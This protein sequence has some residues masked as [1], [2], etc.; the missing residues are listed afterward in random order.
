MRDGLGGDEVEEEAAHA[1][2]SS[3]GSEGL[4]LSV[5]PPTQ[6]PTDA[7]VTALRR[8]LDSM[9]QH[10]SPRKEVASGVVWRCVRGEVIATFLMTIVSTSAALQPSQPS[11]LAPCAQPVGGMMDGLT[12][13]GW[14]SAV[15]W[16]VGHGLV[17]GA[18]SWAV[19]GAH[20]SLP[21]TI[22]LLVTR[23]VSLLRACLHL[24]AQ[25]CGALLA[26]PV[27]LG[28]LPRPPRPPQLAPHLTAVQGW[29]AEFLA[30]L[31]VTLISLSAY[32]AAHAPS[33]Y[34][35]DAHAQHTTPLFAPGAAVPVVAAHVAAAL[36]SSSLVWA[37]T[38]LDPWPSLLSQAP[39]PVTGCS[40]WDQPWVVCWQPSLTSILLPRI[41][42][43]SFPINNLPTLPGIPPGLQLLP[44]PSP[45]HAECHS[46]PASGYRF[47]Q[48]LYL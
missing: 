24:L 1:H 38:L 39:G 18:L 16:A 35:K 40:G 32:E 44:H 43:L 19:R 37:S 46:R 47:L 8:Y 2:T 12:D 5:P 20:M 42:T 28:L 36:F 21:T 9:P 10:P 29:G 30:T 34:T 7:P 13:T 31:V 48:D 23:R 17:M 6:P 11:I 45:P 3:V 22:A 4:S 33:R 15:R 27:L 14:G 25:V 26:A 41:L